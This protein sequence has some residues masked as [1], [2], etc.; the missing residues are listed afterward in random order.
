MDISNT[1]N[2]LINNNSIHYIMQGYSQLDQ[3][4]D[5]QTENLKI[6]KVVSVHLQGIP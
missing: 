5:F 2:T 4:V 3:R 6:A 1:P